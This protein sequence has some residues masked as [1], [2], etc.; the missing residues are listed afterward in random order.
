MMS[1]KFYIKANHLTK[2]SVVIID[3]N[4]YEL[5]FWGQNNP[6]PLNIFESRN[7]LETLRKTDEHYN[8]TGWA[9]E[10]LPIKENK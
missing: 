9:Y 4:Y 5:F 1:D 7:I 8:L 2:R 6:M 3:H 10:I